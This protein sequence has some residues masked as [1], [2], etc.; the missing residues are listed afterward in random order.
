MENNGLTYIAPD[1]MLDGVNI[2]GITEG[3]SDID[4]EIDEG[5][6][7]NSGDSFYNQNYT[8]LEQARAEK[9]AELGIKPID[10]NKY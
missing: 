10:F 6:I 8:L 4:G 1:E 2:E 9:A 3:I 5:I 7:D